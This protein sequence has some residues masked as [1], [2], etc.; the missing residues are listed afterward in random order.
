MASTR[1]IYSKNE[2]LA[3][4]PLADS[5]TFSDDIIAKFSIIEVNDSTPIA[6]RREVD[7]DV[8]NNNNNNNNT[9]H[10]AVTGA[11]TSHPTASATIANH[12][13]NSSSA[14]KNATQTNSSVDNTSSGNSN[15]NHHNN[16]SSTQVSG[17]YSDHNNNNNSGGGYNGLY[18]RDDNGRRGQMTD[19][20]NVPSRNWRGNRDIETF[21]EGYKYELERNAVQQRHV[22]ETMQREDEK[23]EQVQ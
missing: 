14:Y 11:N 8:N 19:R 21:E 13:Q 18:N 20:F 5:I 22:L 15:N 23:K 12:H 2:L 6:R 7:R 3:L 4:A 10:H 1:I 17:F 16:N 9:E